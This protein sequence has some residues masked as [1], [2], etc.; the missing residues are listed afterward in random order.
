MVQKGAVVTEYGIEWIANRVL[1]DTSVTV[2]IAV[3]SG[4]FEP[5]VSTTK[6]SNELYRA[7]TATPSASIQKGTNKPWIIGRIN[8]TGGQNINE[9]EEITEI[10]IFTQS[11]D[12]I[13]AEHRNGIQV[14]E[15]VSRTMQSVIELE[16][17][18]I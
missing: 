2:E 6:L 4:R 10:G 12:M 9:E 7:S 8:I 16:N 5:N 14:P 1:D 3:G 18:G 17:V 13:Y 11:G 15:N